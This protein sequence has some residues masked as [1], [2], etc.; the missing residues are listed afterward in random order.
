MKKSIFYAFL[1]GLK[2][3]PLTGILGCKDIFKNT[4]ICNEC[5]LQNNKN[6]W[7]LRKNNNQIKKNCQKIEKIFYETETAEKIQEKE[8]RDE[9]I[10]L[11]HIEKKQL[12]TFIEKYK[13]EPDK[14]SNKIEKN[15]YFLRH[16]WKF[17]NIETREERLLKNINFALMKNLIIKLLDCSAINLIKNIIKLNELKKKN[18]IFEEQKIINKWLLEIYIKDNKE[19]YKKNK[20]INQ[21]IKNKKIFLRTDDTFLPWKEQEIKNELEDEIFNE[22]FRKTNKLLFLNNTY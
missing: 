20:K 22:R 21:K 1:I 18:Q 4:S 14:Y 19:L 16:F 11:I 9:R 10:H 13:N 3:I 5:Q 17:L 7:K 15:I 8:K 2:Y 6:Q 12:N